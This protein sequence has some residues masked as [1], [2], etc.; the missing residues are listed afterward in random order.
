MVEEHH[1][2]GVWPG[3]G[4]EAF[5]AD[6]RQV[7]AGH[8]VGNHDAAVAVHL[9]DPCLA[10]YRV[11]D[12]HDR[13][14]VGVGDGVALGYLNQPELTAERFV[15]DP[16]AGAAGSEARMYRTGDLGQWRSDGTIEYLGRNDH[17]VKIRGFRIELGEIEARLVEKLKAYMKEHLPDYATLRAGPEDDE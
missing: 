4:G 16:Y 2:D 3:I 1:A 10:V 7:E 13:V 14:G 9:T 11:G 6:A 5:G 12:R 15:A 8:Y 17:Q